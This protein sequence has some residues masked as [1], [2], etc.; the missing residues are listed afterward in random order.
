MLSTKANVICIL[1]ILQEYSDEQHILTMKDIIS[2]ME[3]LYGL[4]ADRRTVYSAIALLND[5]GYDVSTFEENKVGYFLRGRQLEPSEVSLLTEAV[6]SFPFLPAKQSERLI[7]KLQNVLSVHQRKRYRHLSVVRQDRKTDNRQVFWNMELLDEAIAEK[8]QVS[9]TYLRYEEDKKLHPRR[10]KPYTVNPYEMVYMNEHYYLVCNSVGHEGTTLYRMEL[11]R[12]IKK[13]E[14]KW[15]RAPGNKS[16]VRK[17][18]YAFSGEPERVMLLC[19]KGILGDV[20]DKFGS[21][22]QV[23]PHDDT[24][25][26]VSFTVPPKGVKFWA[27]QYLPYVEVVQPQWLRDEI[28]ESLSKSRY[29]AKERQ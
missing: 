2:K 14:T 28:V 21:D 12:D 13:L 22:V 29:N 4:K 23:S 10:E 5:L 17:A 11:I 19:E 6:Y 25:L 1:K 3:S 24:R 8:R 20:I 16:E 7:D 26:T 18:V 9:F 15:D 27:L